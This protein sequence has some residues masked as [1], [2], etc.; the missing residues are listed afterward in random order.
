MPAMAIPSKPWFSLI[1]AAIAFS[2]DYCY[3]L[4]TEVTPEMVLK[5]H[6]K[7]NLTAFSNIISNSG[8]QNSSREILMTFRIHCTFYFG[9]KSQFASKF[10]FKLRFCVL[11]VYC[12]QWKK[13]CT[14]RYVLILWTLY[15]CN[16]IK[17]HVPKKVY[18]FRM[19]NFNL[20]NRIWF[21]TPSN[22]S[23]VT[24]DQLL[25]CQ[26]CSLKRVFLA[27]S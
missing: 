11:L 14:F 21:Y 3:V 12:V 7:L 16:I 5:W 27:L 22:A 17:F 13:L 2:L 24:L 26:S 9:Q 8:M 20:E 18:C 4:C 25:L 15:S 19:E 10:H 23:W 6:P 1:P